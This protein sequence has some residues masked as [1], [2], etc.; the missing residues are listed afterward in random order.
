MISDREL[1]FWHKSAKML[2]MNRRKG[3]FAQGR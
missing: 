2:V 1:R 3:G